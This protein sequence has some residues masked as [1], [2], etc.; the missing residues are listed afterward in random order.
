MQPRYRFLQTVMRK[1]E[2]SDSECG[3]RFY[4]YDLLAHCPSDERYYI[5]RAYKGAYDAVEQ[6]KG[7]TIHRDDP[8]R[9]VMVAEGIHGAEERIRN[10]FLDMA[11]AR[12]P[13]DP[14]HLP[15]VILDS[16]DGRTLDGSELREND[17]L[18]AYLYYDRAVNEEIPAAE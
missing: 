16:A 9:E 12:D 13:L 3:T 14:I 6:F 15:D 18:D 17:S 11:H 7:D 10:L 8:K 2:D 1:E 5:I 4:R